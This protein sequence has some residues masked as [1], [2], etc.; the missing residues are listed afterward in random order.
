MRRRLTEKRPKRTAS[1]RKRFSQETE[2]RKLRA[3]IAKLER[4]IESMDDWGENDME[5]EYD[6]ESQ[7]DGEKDFD[8]VEDSMDI[9]EYADF[10][11]TSEVV[12]SD[13]YAGYVGKL[14]R[15]A[16]VL[17]EKGRKD[18]ALRIDR[19]SDSIEKRIEEGE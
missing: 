15:I 2:R 9:D 7:D 5:D 13:R 6:L 8:V 11:G 3:R 1:A 19:V 12:A 17:E 16:D 18:L 14:D 10:D 4:E